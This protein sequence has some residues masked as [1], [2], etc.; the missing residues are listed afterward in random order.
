ML[1]GI[2]VEA[3]ML[4]VFKRLP[5]EEFI[6][7]SE[8]NDWAMLILLKQDCLSDKY[9]AI[10]GWAVSSLE[11]PTQ[12]IIVKKARFVKYDERILLVSEI[13]H[14]LISVLQDNVFAVIQDAEME[15][16]FYEKVPVSEQDENK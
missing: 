9:N 4:R 10:H 1:F 3:L 2:D 13:R 8:K 15:L 12:K 14:D 5:P 16:Q 7:I 6:D 11:N